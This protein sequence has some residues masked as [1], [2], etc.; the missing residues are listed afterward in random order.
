MNTHDYRRAVDALPFG[1]RLPGAVYLL[2]PRSIGSSPDDLVND[3]L[4]LVLR[5]KLEAGK[6]T[7]L[8]C[9]YR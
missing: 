8:V 4:P 5:K 6:G 1:K 7:G 2:D 3:P 9:Q